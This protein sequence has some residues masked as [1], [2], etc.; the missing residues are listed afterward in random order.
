MLKSL[1][2]IG[3]GFKPLAPLLTNSSMQKRCNN[4]ELGD[5]TPIYEESSESQI[6]EAPKQ[7]SAA[8]R[9]RNKSLSVTPGALLGEEEDFAV[10][11]APQEDAQKVTKV[12]SEKASSSE[13][14]KSGKSAEP[15]SSQR[16]SKLSKSHSSFKSSKDEKRVRKS[17]S[18]KKND[19]KSKTKMMK[20]ASNKLD[21]QDFLNTSQKRQ[22]QAARSLQVPI[23]RQYTNRSHNTSIG[24]SSDEH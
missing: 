11:A 24:K 7:K 20:R 5:G 15:G 6:N 13:L 10:P 22:I 17:R 23:V 21:D 2:K 8:K 18:R 12:P 16:E 9:P 1:G 14:A 3:G 4:V 19:K